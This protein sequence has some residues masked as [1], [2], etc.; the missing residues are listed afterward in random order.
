MFR[1]NE[2]TGE[3]EKMGRVLMSLEIVPEKLVESYP[4]GMGRSEPNMNPTLKEPAGRI[5]LSLNPFKTLGQLCGPTVA[6][7]CFCFVFIAVMICIGAVVGPYISILMNVATNIDKPMVYIPVAILSSVCLL[8]CL[9][10]LRNYIFCCC[11]K[12]EK[13]TA[14]EKMSLLGKERK[15]KISDPEEPKLDHQVISIPT[16]KVSSQSSVELSTSLRTKRGF[17]QLDSERSV[18]GVVGEKV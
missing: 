17:S 7:R 6:R 3:K 15:A 4:A 16:E 1:T 12:K 14:E 5:S 18:D 9:F 10:A 8:C 13:G 2:K 11:R